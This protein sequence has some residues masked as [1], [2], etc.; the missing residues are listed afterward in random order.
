M[1]SGSRWTTAERR[2]KQIAR[3]TNDAKRRPDVRSVTTE[4][5]NVTEIVTAVGTIATD[6]T[7]KGRQPAL[8]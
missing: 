4:I 6:T 2:G 7:G 3:G 1:N 8:I 5:G